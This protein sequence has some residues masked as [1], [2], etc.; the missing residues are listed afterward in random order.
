[1]SDWVI[2]GRITGLYGLHGWVRVFSHTQPR[3]R[4]GEYHPLYLQN[5]G[6]WRPIDVQEVRLHSGGILLKLDGYADRMAATRLLGCDLAIRR[7]QLPA[8]GAD[9]YYWVDLEGL[10]VFT[11]DGV[12]LGRVERLFETGANTV[13]VVAGERERLIPFIRGD[14]IKR[15]DLAQGLM[16][17]DWDPDF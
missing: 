10:R 2:V 7:E 8:L 15:I 16:E 14:V 5:K 13:V 9:E 4:I 12:E 11:V 3:E 17:V 1:M 6:E